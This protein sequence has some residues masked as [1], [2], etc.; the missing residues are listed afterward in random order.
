MP[1]ETALIVTIA[2][3]FGLAFLF[4][5]LAVRLR[6]PP[7]V[8]YLV[9]GVCIGPFTP[10]Y[11]ADQGLASQLAEIGVILLMFGVG[12]HFSIRDLLAV[13][14]IAI[15]GATV[16]IAVAT[17]LGAIVAHFWGW[18]WSAGLVFGLALS[19]ASTV[20]LLRALEAR[21]LLDSADGRIAVGWLVIE[22]LVTVLALVL[23]PAIAAPMG[24]VSPEAAGHA[25]TASLPMAI[26]LTFLKVGI[27]LAL[28][29]FVG[30]RVVPWLLERVARTGSRELFTLAV[31]AVALGIAVGAAALFDVSFALGA[32]FAGVVI[33]ES[34]L[35][36]Q[37]A[38]DALPLQDAFAVL[39]FVSVGMLFDPT[40]LV[41]Q[42]LHVLATV[43]IIFIGKSVAAFGLVL[44][45]RYPVRTA[46]LISASLA[47]IGE[48]S[49]ILAGLGVSLGLIPEA[50]RSLV[51]AGAIISITMNP[52]L[53]GLVNPI[54]RWL[55]ARPRLLDALE[56]SGGAPNVLAT[57]P[58]VSLHDHA[59]IIGY[60]RV[61]GTIGETLSRNGVPY[62]VIERDRLMVESLRKRGVQSV[63]GDAA[64]AGLLEQVHVETARILIVTAPEPYHARRIVELA[65]QINPDI[66]TVV[67]THSDSER[68]YLE[69][70]G[71]GRA[72]MGERE[73]AFGIAHFALVSLGRTDDEADVIIDGV[74]RS[75]SARSAE[76]GTAA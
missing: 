37:A 41:R 69:R 18:S 51:L 59:I 72:V 19:V 55:R 1:H 40:V 60:G 58:P 74:R 67:R 15:P 48:F 31:L 36:H 20:V 24:G 9:A 44:L 63:F 70:S 42:P 13:R 17:A 4:G 62:A 52:V 56:R 21:G 29:L 5:L 33:S 53:F 66:V 32:F 25:A 57:A 49:F 46:L 61:G 23:L 34:D 30:T 7:L 27:F 38:A 75:Q 54:D 45:F 14:R 50:S 8:G 43:L 65:R 6:L 71:V 39:F 2:A 68:L 10:G 35:S 64:R 16:Q 22:D 73:L 26:G 11:V 47:Q 28:M 3:G 12:L 76:S